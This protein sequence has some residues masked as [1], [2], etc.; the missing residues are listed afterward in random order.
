MSIDALKNSLPEFAEDIKFNLSSLVKDESLS[1]QQKWGTFLASALATRSKP[2][3]KAIELEVSNHL[4]N[5]A[6]RAAKAAHAIMAMNNVYYRFLGLVKNDTYRTMPAGLRMSIIN[7]P[8]VD[9]ADF[10]LWSLAV[11]AINACKGCINAH[12]QE[13]LNQQITTQQI[14]AAIRIASV[15]QAIAAILDSE[16][17]EEADILKAA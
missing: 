16:K 10:E 2:I 13:L 9:K 1:E 17:L 11:S 4:S 8:G 6:V 3:I 15:V 5:E 14:Q 12:E 7:D